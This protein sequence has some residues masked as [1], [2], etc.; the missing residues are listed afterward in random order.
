M[1]GKKG[2]DD[3]MLTAADTRALGICSTCNFM[4][5]CTKRRTWIGP[6]HHCEEFDDHAEAP[7]RPARL[8]VVTADEP[9]IDDGLA[10]ICVNCAHRGTC[11]LPKAEGGIWH[12][13]EYE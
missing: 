7:S 12:C 1:N 4:E 10:G 5:S 13:E 9:E 11:T 6:V 2:K 3:V 8:E